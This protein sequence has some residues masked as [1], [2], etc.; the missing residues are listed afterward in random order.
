MGEDRERGKNKDHIYTNHQP[1]S[2][3]GCKKT[4]AILLASLLPAALVFVAPDAQRFVP[5]NVSGVTVKAWT[6]QD[7]VQMGK[8]KTMAVAVSIVTGDTQQPGAKALK[9]D[10]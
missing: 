10:G 5:D 4:F 3:M 6:T 8:S 7:L 2:T 9:I 1:S